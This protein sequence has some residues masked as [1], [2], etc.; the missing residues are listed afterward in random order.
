MAVV[1]ISNAGLEHNR[2]NLETPKAALRQVRKDEII[3][4]EI[5]TPVKPKKHWGC[6]TDL[7][8]PVVR[9]LQPPDLTSANIHSVYVCR[10]EIEAGD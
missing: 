9:I 7:V 5:G 6:E 1:R 10:H 4:V 8:W 3:L 2:L